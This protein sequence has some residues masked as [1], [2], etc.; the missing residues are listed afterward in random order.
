MLFLKIIAVCNSK[1]SNYLKSFKLDVNT[2]FII[3]LLPCGNVNLVGWVTDTNY[4]L[5]SSYT[6]TLP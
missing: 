1:H 4:R 5:H 3:I 6:I 2:S